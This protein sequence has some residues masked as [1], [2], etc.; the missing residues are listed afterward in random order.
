[1][2]CTH[3]GSGSEGVEGSDSDIEAGGVHDTQHR[4]TCATETVS[5]DRGEIERMQ[6]KQ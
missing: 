4:E 2:S 6:P 5:T 1:M 3:S